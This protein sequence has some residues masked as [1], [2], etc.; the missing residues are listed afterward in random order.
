M[1]PHGE[2]SEATRPAT[3]LARNPFRLP[4]EPSESELRLRWML[5]PDDIRQVLLCRGELHRR[6]SAIQLCTLPIHGRLVE[7]YEAIPFAIHN[8]LAQQ[9]DLPP[10]LFVHNPERDATESEQRSRIRDCLGFTPFDD[11]VRQRLE[12]WLVEQAGHAGIQTTWRYDR[13]GA[14]S[15]RKAA[16]TVHV[17]YAGD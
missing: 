10:V 11:A 3:S 7:D 1:S 13:R 4:K 8:H 16:L 14:I 15:R 6:S 5:S 9:L 12:Q 2:A 17:P